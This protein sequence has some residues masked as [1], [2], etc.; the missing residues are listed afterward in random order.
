MPRYAWNR[1][2]AARNADTGE[3]TIPAWCCPRKRYAPRLLRRLREAD[4]QVGRAVAGGDVVSWVRGRRAVRVLQQAA[5]A[6]VGGRGVLATAAN[7]ASKPPAEEEFM[8]GLGP[9]GGA[10]EAARG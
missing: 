7:S 2:R 10:D 5:M 9:P 4:A 8:Y 6:G 3:G 1:I